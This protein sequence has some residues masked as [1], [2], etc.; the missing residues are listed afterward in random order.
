MTDWYVF[1]STSFIGSSWV[2]VDARC[3]AIFAAHG[4][5]VRLGMPEAE[6]ETGREP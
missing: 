2:S 5:Q 6:S 4:L 3:A 1:I